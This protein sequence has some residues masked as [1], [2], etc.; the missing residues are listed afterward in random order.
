MIRWHLDKLRERTII[1]NPEYPVLL[2]RHP[3]VV[4]PVQGRIYN[5][6]R[7]LL[8]TL[9][10]LP[11]SHDLAGTIGARNLGQDVR[12]DPRVLPLGG[13]DVPPVQRRRLQPDD[14]LPRT[15]LRLG[16]VLVDQLVGTFEFVQTNGFHGAPFGRVQ[17]FSRSAFQRVSLVRIRD[18]CFRVNH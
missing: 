10:P 2:A 5:D 18:S 13:E 15:R 12:R 4:P 1:G 8:G 3:R 7:P 6:V 11:A 16:H 17:H 9:R 14:G